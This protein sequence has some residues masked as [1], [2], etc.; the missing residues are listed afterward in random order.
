MDHFEDEH[1]DEPHF[2]EEEVEGT[3]Q[4]GRGLSIPNWKEQVCC[5][6][7][8]GKCIS[9][10]SS[11]F[12]KHVAAEVRDFR[13]MPLVSHWSQ[14]KEDR[15][16]AFWIRIKETI[17]FQEEDMAKMSMIRHMTLHI[18]EHAHKEYRNKLKKKY[19]TGKP[20][21]EYQRTPPNVD[22]QQWAALVSYWN[23]EKTKEIA[24]KNKYNRRLKTMNHTTGAKFYAKV[25]AELRKKHGKEADPVSFFRHCHTRKDRTWIDETSEHTG[26]TMERNIQTMIESGHD[27]GDELRT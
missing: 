4:R 22:P 5:F 25:R 8:S 18:A 16:E 20:V 12:S 17:I 2:K 3:T 6:D 19:Y 21:E 15:R 26:I 9:E 10:N 23:K 27:D 13:H 1:A 14:I 7:A 11:A 24:A